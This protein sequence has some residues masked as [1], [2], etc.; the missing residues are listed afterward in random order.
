M[1]DL[2]PFQPTAADRRPKPAGSWLFLW[3]WL[4]ACMALHI[5]LLAFSFSGL[6]DD[7]YA[8]VSYV[9][10]LA[11]AQL[12]CLAGWVAFGPLP[13]LTRLS[14]ALFLTFL[15]W[16]ATIEAMSQDGIRDVT[17]AVLTA[18]LAFGQFGFVSIGL[19]I[20]RRI[21]PGN[22]EMVADEESAS[23]PPAPAPNHEMRFSLLQLMIWTTG[24][25]ILLA[26]GG[27][28]FQNRIGPFIRNLIDIFGV[29]TMMGSSALVGG[30]QVI[31]WLRWRYDYQLP[32]F[33]LASIF[34]ITLVE[35]GILSTLEQASGRPIDDLL[36]MGWTLFC[37]HAWESMVI[38]ST[39]ALLHFAGLR[40]IDS[41][42]EVDT[43][44]AAP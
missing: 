8:I 31:A 15:V 14:A 33:A 10:G 36:M 40:W 4:A 25:A 44:E 42:S 26:I 17:M 11:A 34:G 22:L 1:N 32:L 7:R 2:V 27:V 6:L 9:I 18:I 29:G 30:W 16:M 23:A 24:A 37:L 5:G 20:A 13:F 28:V 21:W 38:W 12:S 43:N 3:L 19:A 41:R 39:G 35:W